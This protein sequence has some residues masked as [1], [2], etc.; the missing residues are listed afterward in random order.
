MHW[1]SVSEPDEATG[2]LGSEEMP[3]WSQVP[4]YCGFKTERIGCR[5]NQRWATPEQ[6]MAQCQEYGKYLAWARNK[7]GLTVE[8]FESLL[9]GAASTGADNRGTAGLC[10]L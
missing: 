5:N 7:C 10:C 6:Q 1:A 4:K 8:E 9:R 2:D 3:R